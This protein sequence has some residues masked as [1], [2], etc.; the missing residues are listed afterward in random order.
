MCSP[1]FPLLLAA[2]G[3]NVGEEGEG[4]SKERSPPSMKLEGRPSGK[5]EPGVMEL[6]SVMEGVLLMGLEDVL[7]LVNASVVAIFVQCCRGGVGEGE[8]LVE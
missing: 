5:M 6:I 8:D 4:V 7:V 1:P 3:E 2:C